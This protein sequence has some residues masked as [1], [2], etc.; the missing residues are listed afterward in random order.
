[1]PPQKSLRLTALELNMVNMIIEG[2][3]SEFDDEDKATLDRLLARPDLTADETVILLKI[4]TQFDRGPFLVIEGSE[5][6]DIKDGGNRL[7]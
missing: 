4:K 6:T 3:L 5:I 7:H 2:E 1:L